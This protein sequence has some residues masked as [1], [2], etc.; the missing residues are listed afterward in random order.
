MRQ[1][2]A[3]RR[4]DKSLRLYRSGDQLP[5][6]V[7]TTCHLVCTDLN[8]CEAVL[9]SLFQALTNSRKMRFKFPFNLIGNGRCFFV[10]LFVF[11]III[12]IFNR[13]IMTRTQIW[14]HRQTAQNKDFCAVLQMDL[15]RVQCCLPSIGYIANCSI[16]FF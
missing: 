11:L 15:T 13:A 2:A 7:V 10:C 16:Q 8:V 14:V 5:Q 1:V 12:F 4:G 6:H 9:V 3:T